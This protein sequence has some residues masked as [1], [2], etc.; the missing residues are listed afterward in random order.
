MH[1]RTDFEDESWERDLLGMVL[2]HY[3][4]PSS[5]R[6]YEAFYERILDGYKHG[7]LI[8]TTALAMFANKD[9]LTEEE[10]WKM[11]SEAMVLDVEHF[12][13]KT[14]SQL[15]DYMKKLKKDD[16]EKPLS[17]VR[18][19]EYS[20]LK[21]YLKNSRKNPELYPLDKKGYKE[22]TMMHL[23]ARMMDEKALKIMFDCKECDVLKTAISDECLSPLALFLYRCEGKHQHIFRMMIG[24]GCD[25]LACNEHIEDCPLH[26]I[27]KR[28]GN[29]MSEYLSFL[30]VRD[31]PLMI[32]LDCTYRKVDMFKL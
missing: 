9:E 6:D 16:S 28:S 13:E 8:V 18:M 25:L 26:I 22:Y 23:A 15:G 12:F 31:S 10:F 21:A 4:Y 7:S 17:F 29:G 14:F 32:H 1:K 19:K 20:G 3:E 11:S 27:L 30:E 24:S 2:Q 5:S